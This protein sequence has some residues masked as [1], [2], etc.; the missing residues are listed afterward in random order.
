MM[1]MQNM[2]LQV[3]SGSISCSG[4]DFHFPARKETTEEKCPNGYQEKT[5]TSIQEELVST[6]TS[7]INSAKEFI[8]STV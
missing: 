1:N 8:Y 2:N 4:R 5:L 3:R 6:I 7:I